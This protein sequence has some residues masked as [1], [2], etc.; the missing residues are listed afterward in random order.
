MKELYILDTCYNPTAAS[1][2][3]LFSY[4]SAWKKHGVKTTVFYLFPYNK[5]VKCDR[6]LDD[7]NFVYLWEGTSCDNKYYNTVRSIIKLRKILKPSIPVYVYS[8]INCLYFIQK[9]NIRVFHEQTENPD[10]VGRIGGV[11][12]KYLYW[13]VLYLQAD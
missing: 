9:R 4:A 7:I 6:Y 1:N 13:H 11:V 3:R 2:N 8:M 10:V 12:G 5:G